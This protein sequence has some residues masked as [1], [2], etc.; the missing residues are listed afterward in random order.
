MGDEISKRSALSIGA[1]RM[2]L[3]IDRLV[4]MERLDSRSEAADARLDY[5]EPYKYGVVV[6]EIA[7]LRSQLEEAE[8]KRKRDVQKAAEEASA[9][10]AIL[11]LRGRDR[12]IDEVVKPLKAKLK[13]SEAVVEAGKTHLVWMQGCVKSMIETVELSNQGLWKKLMERIKAALFAHDKGKG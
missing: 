5:G 10:Q 11:E 1:D 8:R 2:A 9:K 6:S 7:T 4:E 12:F 3:A 13:S